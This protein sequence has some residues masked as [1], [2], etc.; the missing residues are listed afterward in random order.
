M[1]A[2]PDKSVSAAWPNGWDEHRDAQILRIAHET[3]AADRLHWVEQSLIFLSKTGKS[4][5]DR[6]ALFG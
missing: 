3:T 2:T 6:K 4:Y 1:E 5:L